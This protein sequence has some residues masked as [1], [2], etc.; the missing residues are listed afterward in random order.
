MLQDVATAKSEQD[1]PQ[2]ILFDGG[3]L[4]RRCQ[5]VTIVE[6]VLSQLPYRLTRK[7]DGVV[8][9]SFETN[10]QALDTLMNL[11]ECTFNPPKITR[12]VR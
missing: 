8:L 6:V 2:G 9:G 11:K 5:F 4:Q 7:R 1:V 10:Q 3:D 12:K